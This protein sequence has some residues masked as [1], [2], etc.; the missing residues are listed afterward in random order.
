[1]YE[2]RQASGGRL[3]LENYDPLGHDPGVSLL[4]PRLYL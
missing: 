1:M 3:G 2:E 4:L